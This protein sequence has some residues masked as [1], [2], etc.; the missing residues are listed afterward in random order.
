M[1][2]QCKEEDWWI[3]VGDVE[4]A[5]NNRAGGSY[6][7]ASL[8]SPAS[9]RML[10]GNLSSYVGEELQHLDGTS[11]DQSLWLNTLTDAINMKVMLED[12]L[13]DAQAAKHDELQKNMEKEFLVTKTVGNQ[14]VWQDLDAWAP[15]IRQEFEQLVNKKCAVRQITKDELRQMASEQKLP[16][17]VLPGKM[18]HTRKSGTGA[19]KS[20][21]VV[22]GNYAA[23]DHSEHYAGGVDSQ[24][25]RTQLRV[26]ANKQWMVGCT[27]IRTAFLNAPRRDR[28]KLVAMEIPVVFRKL[29]LASS[30]HIWLIDKALYGLTT[31]PRDWSLHRDEVIPTISWHRDRDGRAVQGAFRKTPDE[32][33]WR[34]E[35]FDEKSGESHWIGLMSVYVDDLLFTAEEGAL[36][37]AARAIEKVWAISD[38]EKTGEG[39]IVKYCGFEIEAAQD[40]HGNADGFVVSQRKYEQEMIQRFGIEKSSEFPHVRLC[41][42]DDTLAD[43]IKAEDVKTAQSM[44]GA[45]LWLSTRTRPDIAMTVATACRLST[46]NPQRS[47]EVS[48]AVMQYIKGVPGGLH[49]P[50]GVP[51]DTWG[52]RNQLKVERHEALIEVFSDIAFGVGS[53]HRSLQGLVLC[54]GGVPVAWLSSQQPFV[55]YSTAEAE[56]VSYGEALNAGR[57]MEALICSMTGQDVKNNSY[58]RVIYGDNTAAIGMAHGTATSTWRTRHLRVRAAF[59]KEALDGVAPGGAWKLLHL[60]GT[61]LVADGLTK[62]LSGQAFFKFLDD[63]GIKRDSPMCIMEGDQNPISNGGTSNGNAKITAIMTLATGSLLLSGVDGEHDVEDDWETAA[64]WTTGAILMSLG[65]IYAGQVIHS[66]ASCCLRRFSATEGGDGRRQSGHRN[67]DDSSD[68]D[69]ILVVSEDEAPTS[70]ERS[71]R[72]ASTRTTSSSATTSSAT[73]GATRNASKGSRP[74]DKKIESCSAG[75]STSLPIRPPS[76]SSTAELDV[77]LTLRQRSGSSNA[78]A[79]GEPAASASAA[80]G[81]EGALE[82]GVDSTFNDVSK[83]GSKQINLHNPWN[84]F[85]HAYKGKGL[86]STTLAQMYNRRKVEHS[87]GKP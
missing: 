74:N 13:L 84:R 69:D 42:D 79:A 71:K 20:R 52:K 51:R 33:V 18:V 49:Y 57:S 60:R 86:S 12:H 61:E 76:G 46:R 27:D 5:P 19:F 6:P 81:S 35:E 38:V 1:V 3:G 37:A 56:L 66:V 31:S 41:E 23:P 67:P 26:G 59:I 53:K 82:G 32:N 62:P 14:E 44:A 28:Q 9:L 4:E 72:G 85:Q 2:S 75:A 87:K 70:R 8:A 21:A 83:G 16:I 50:K 45:L 48:H 39:R 34:M 68:S 63:L 36:D 29:G 64:I 78:C 22:C 25:V 73:K 65:A 17:E 80:S 47:I 10:H 24:Q 77:S 15:S 40:N 58:E 7:V 55:T 43:D 11:M 54:L 30:Q